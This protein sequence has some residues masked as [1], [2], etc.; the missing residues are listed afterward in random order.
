MPPEIPSSQRWI[1]PTPPAVEAQIL[2]HWTSREVPQPTL[3]IHSSNEHPAPQ[4]PDIQMLGGGRGALPPLYLT[5][6]PQGSRPWVPLLCHSLCPRPPPQR[7]QT[8]ACKQKAELACNLQ[9]RKVVGAAGS[10]SL[11]WETVGIHLLVW[12][13]AVP[14]LLWLVRISGMRQGEAGSQPG[15][16][17]SARGWRRPGSFLPKENFSLNSVWGLSHLRRQLNEST[18]HEL[19]PIPHPE[20]VPVDVSHRPAQ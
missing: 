20:H 7:P 13:Q 4:C 12:S 6:H 18:T 1:E 14:C 15:C 9:E 10:G 17:G 8:Q 11:S 16:P 2:N 3:S 5:A 19:W